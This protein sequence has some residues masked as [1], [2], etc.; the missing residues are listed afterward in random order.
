MSSDRRYVVGGYWD[1]AVRVWNI[2]TGRQV[3]D[4]LC[5]HKAWVSAVAISH[6]CRWFASTSYDKT[7]R[8]RELPSG[9]TIG[10]PLVG[11]TIGVECVAISSDDRLVISGSYD[12]T[13]RVWDV[14]S[15]KI[16]LGPLKHDWP[17]KSVYMSRDNQ[18]IISV[19]LRDKVYLWSVSTRELLKSTTHGPA[20]AHLIWKARNGWNDGE[21]EGTESNNK[22]S[23]ITVVRQD[24]YICDPTKN[25]N[26]FK[27]V[28][29]FANEV[30]D[31][32]VDANGMLWV[33][34]LGKD[35]AKL[36]MTTERCN[37]V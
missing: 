21:D 12:R 23:R 20:C 2:S 3:G 30:R 36:T 14:R 18:Q 27:K 34:F 19:D 16:I 8:L 9:K 24:V 11:H 6:D 13:F 28:G 1:S 17:V 33:C 32:V 5:G 26:F 35:L 10:Q 25:E 7:L 15:G 29:Q 22:K 37:T 31:W 4:A